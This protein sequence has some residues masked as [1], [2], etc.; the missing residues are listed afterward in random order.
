MDNSIDEKINEIKENIKKCENI[1]KEEENRCKEFIFNM[2]KKIEEINKAFNDYK[3]RNLSI[4]SIYKNTKN[5]LYLNYNFDL[6]T[7]KID[8]GECLSNTFNKL[9]TF[10][11]NKNH[12]RTREYADHFITEKYCD[13]IIKKCIFI[14]QKLIAFMFNYDNRIYYIYNNNNNYQT[15]FIYYDNF[16]KD[17][18]SLYPN[19]IIIIDELNILMIYYIEYDNISFGNTH[20]IEKKDNINYVII[21]LF[22]KD[23]FLC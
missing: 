23:K 14:N 5:N 6:N 10:Y 4:I 16:I 7:L 22:N 18:Y 1:I 17:I 9:F 15:K 8:K 19:K 12:I 20:L 11:N 2:K 21:D 13:K 3:N